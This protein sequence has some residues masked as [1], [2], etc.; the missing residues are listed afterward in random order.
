MS[1]KQ[2]SQQVGLI[3]QKARSEKMPNK[4]DVKKEKE[5]LNEKFKSVCEDWQ[6]I[7]KELIKGQKEIQKEGVA[8]ENP[9]YRNEFKKAFQS[10]EYKNGMSIYNQSVKLIKDYQNNLID[11]GKICHQMHDLE[12]QIYGKRKEIKDKPSYIKSSKTF[13]RL[14]YKEGFAVKAL[15]NSYKKFYPNEVSSVIST[16][17]DLADTAN[18]KL[19]LRSAEKMSNELKEL[20]PGVRRKGEII[21]DSETLTVKLK[22]AEQKVE[23]KNQK[24]P[25]QKSPHP[26]R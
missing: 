20:L 1:V 18:V 19:H 15:K 26:V 22:Q 6:S 25:V 4:K 8:L 10:N 13:K 21:K 2:Q 9:E 14:N 3:K 12:Q 7:Y 11:Y 16:I 5:L 23:Q 17:K 24:L